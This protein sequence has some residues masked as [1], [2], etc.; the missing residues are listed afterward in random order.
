M[1]VNKKVDNQINFS[2]VEDCFKVNTEN[3]NATLAAKT[4]ATVVRLKFFF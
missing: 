3:N 2:Q 1:D 4:K